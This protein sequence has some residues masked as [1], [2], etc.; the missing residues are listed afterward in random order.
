MKYLEEEINYN[1][2]QDLASIAS[3]FDTILPQEHARGVSAITLEKWHA[4]LKKYL[5][6]NFSLT[7][8]QAFAHQLGVNTEVIVSQQEWVDKV[9][10]MPHIMQLIQEYASSGIENLFSL[11]NS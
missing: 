8:S 5:T 9:R 7:T 2:T 11:P 6:S 1:K 4:Y 10:A 3:Y